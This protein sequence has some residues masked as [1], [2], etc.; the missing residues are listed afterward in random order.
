MFISRLNERSN[1]VIDE[2]VKHSKE[3]IDVISERIKAF[4]DYKG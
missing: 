1:V 2:H 3:E 4:V